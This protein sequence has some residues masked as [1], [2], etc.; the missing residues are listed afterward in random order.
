MI[1]ATDDDAVNLS[2]SLLTRQLNPTARTIVRF[3]DAEF[4]EKVQKALRVD[5]A[6]SAA[7]IAAPSFVAAALHEGTKLA[8][9]FDQFLLT[10]VEHDGRSKKGEERITLMRKRDK[11][12][13]FLPLTGTAS[14]QGERTLAVVVHRLA[15]TNET[16]PLSS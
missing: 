10:I 8:F 12:C 13:R 11:D 14:L 1:A 16:G 2:V 5:A 9:V 3:F 7:A 4:A 15:P 6:M